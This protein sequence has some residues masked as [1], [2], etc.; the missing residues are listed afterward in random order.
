M[1]QGLIALLTPATLGW[2][3][4]IHRQSI[5]DVSSIRKALK[6]RIS[7]L[8]EFAFDPDY[9]APLLQLAA[10]MARDGFDVIMVCDRGSMLLESAREG[11]GN[12]E[13]FL[14]GDSGDVRP[15][16]SEHRRLAS[17]LKGRGSSLLI[18][19]SI[20][21][22]V[23]MVGHKEAYLL[24]RTLLE[25]LEGRSRVVFVLFPWAHEHWEVARFRALVPDV[26]VAVAGKILRIED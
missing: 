11:W 24:I 10:R 18:Y 4:M 12:F 6:Q 23:R 9:A 8:L 25:S 5:W 13:V 17:E 3:G 19:D 20:T 7:V 21:A 16:V 1:L 15:V 22:L 14:L 2:L 26:F